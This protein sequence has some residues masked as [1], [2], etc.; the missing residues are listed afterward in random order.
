M[1]SPQSPAQPLQRLQYHDSL[2]LRL[3]CKQESI[4]RLKVRRYFFIADSAAK[5]NRYLPAPAPGCA[6]SSPS[7][8]ARRLPSASENVFVQFL[9]PARLSSRN[10]TFFSFAILIRQQERHVSAPYCLRI[11]LPS[12]GS[13]SKFSF[14]IPVAESLLLRRISCR[15]PSGTSDPF[16]RSEHKI[17]V[18]HKGAQDNGINRSSDDSL[19]ITPD[20]LL[21]LYDSKYH[22][23]C[24]SG[25]V[26]SILR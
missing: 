12:S 4:R 11:R 3:G 21:Y 18:P 25:Q 26:H 1:L 17:A 24:I 9:H 19:C 2:C 23:I 15:Y 7:L 6:F 10:L 16:R 20:I 14:S 5:N 13:I 22:G 8:S